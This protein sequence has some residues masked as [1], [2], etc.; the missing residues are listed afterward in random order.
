M[1][2]LIIGLTISDSQTRSTQGGKPIHEAVGVFG[3]K[4][5]QIKLIRFG[6]EGFTDGA[7]VLEGSLQIDKV[8]GKYIESIVA[9]RLHQGYAPV[10]SVTL[11]GRM[12]RDPEMKYFE[13]GNCLSEFSLAVNRRKKDAPPDWFNCKLWGKTAQVAADYCRKGSQIGIQGYMDFE[14]WTDRQTG[15][16]RRKLVVTGSTLELIGKREEQTPVAAG[17]YASEADYA[18][19]DF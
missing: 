7:F 17:G 14:T 3:E 19:I 5:H 13:S 4:L 1:N 15:N 18:D 16:E 11:I 8:D 10:S 6:D 9:N 12:G 2:N